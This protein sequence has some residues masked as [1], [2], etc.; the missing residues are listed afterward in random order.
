VPER[1]YIAI[2]GPI[3]VGKTTLA[4]TL[5]AEFGA[6]LLL[7]I[8][9]ENPFLSNFYAD[10]ERFAFQ[11]QI[12][13]LLSRYHQQREVPRFLA[14]QALISD[15]TFAK[16]RLFAH[17]NL[18]GDELE[19]YE[20]LHN[21]L[22][23][24]VVAPDLVVYLRA[25]PATLMER[26]A[27]RDRPYE[28]SM[29]PDYIAAL[30]KAY[31]GFFASYQECRVLAIDTDRLNVV[32]RRADLQGVVERIRKALA[33]DAESPA[34]KAARPRSASWFAPLAGARSAAPGV[35]VAIELYAEVL[36]LQQATGSLAGA[37]LRSGGELG[38]AQSGVTLAPLELPAVDG[39]L[40]ACRAALARIAARVGKAAVGADGEAGG[41]TGPG[42]ESGGVEL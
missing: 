19:T 42:T 16:D 7:E 4:R 21:A 8:F 1:V 32:R 10:R 33:E 12:F 35:N 37:L 2:E 39:A 11:T 38:R 23:E 13:F 30:A 20:R 36:G 40:T 18:H 9:E 25:G 26:I 17:L 6:G 31:E 22:A 29:S 5:Q 15:Y 34:G 41:D 3:G 24:R 28:R 14:Q 27:M